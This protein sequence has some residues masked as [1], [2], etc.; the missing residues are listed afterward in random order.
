MET[1][2]NR[3]D[4][5]EELFTQKGFDDTSTNDIIN[6]IGIARGTLYHHFKSKEDILDAVIERIEDRTLE[7]YRIGPIVISRVLSL[8]K[9]ALLT[10]EE[11]K[12]LTDYL[13]GRL[14]DYTEQNRMQLKGLDLPNIPTNPFGA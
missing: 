4:V 1:E 14:R 13:D 9:G 8:V 12:E 10:E 2:Y 11:R 7:S 5:G 3:V 6:V